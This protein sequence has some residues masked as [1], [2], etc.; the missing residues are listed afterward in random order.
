MCVNGKQN[1]FITL[2]DHQ[3][4]VENNPTVALLN[5]SKNIKTMV[6]KISFN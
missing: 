1:C 2:K 6:D 3:P 4:N 5:P